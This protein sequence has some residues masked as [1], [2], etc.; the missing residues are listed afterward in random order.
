MSAR[1]T[2]VFVLGELSEE[3]I[4]SAFMAWPEFAASHFAGEEAPRV[5]HTTWHEQPVTHVALRLFEVAGFRLMD[6]DGLPETSDLEMVLGRELSKH[7]PV[8]YAFYED[9]I[10]AG[11]GARFEGGELVYRECVDGQVAIPIQRS[12]DATR[13][14]PDLDPSDWIWPH[15][16]RCLTQ[17]FPADFVHPPEDDDAVEK[18]I[19]DA[20]AEA[21]VLPE[22]ARSAPARSAPEETPGRARKRDRVKR[23][24]RGWLK[25]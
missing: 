23:A 11:G 10:M 24:F 19:L 21:I 22:K 15:A 3:A 14:I 4:A 7:F 8:V 16:T 5:G 13:P 17:A 18:M 12:L 9:E 20:K 1:N 25:R 6:E 2:G